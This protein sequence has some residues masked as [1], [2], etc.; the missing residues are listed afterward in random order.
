MHNSSGIATIEISSPSNGK[1]A[2]KATSLP[3]ETV[4][5]DLVVI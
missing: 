5:N 3:Q 2:T 1:H 4:D